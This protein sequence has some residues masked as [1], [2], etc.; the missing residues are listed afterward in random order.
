VAT[1][2][3]FEEL[4]VWK[5]A[6]I[7]ADDD[8][9]L[10]SGSDLAKDYK[11]KEQMNSSSGS[12]MDNI[13]EGFERGGKPEFINFLSFVKGSAGELRSQLYRCLDR[14]YLDLSAF[15]ELKAKTEE[16]SRMIGGFIDYLNQ[17]EIKGLKFKHRV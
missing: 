3:R 14:K 2:T 6:R 10:I 12:I 4:E 15:E 17:T 1:V 7:L 11:L 8:F 16:A 9:K 5:K 13:A